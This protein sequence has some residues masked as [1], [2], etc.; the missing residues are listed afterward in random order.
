MRFFLDSKLMKIALLAIGVVAIVMIVSGASAQT[1]NTS[2]LTDAQKAQLALE[3]AQMAEQ[4]NATPQPLVEDR[5][6]QK[7]TEVGA[8]IGQALAGTAREL[9]VEVNN[10]AN[11][12]VG[13]LSVFLIVW[14][15]FG[16]TFLQVFGGLL[17]LS[18][19]IPIWIWSF[20]KNVVKGQLNEEREYEN[21]KGK[22]VK[23]VSYCYNESKAEWAVWHYVM[24][25]IIFL[26]WILV[27][28][29]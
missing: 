11:T 13:K 9:G 5:E 6:V 20:R 29:S 16:T 10:F 19:S 18:I 26:I 1:I 27:T 4:N 22:K 25:A 17:L 24:L 28:F 15:F 12:P 2:D 14:H 3:A 7:W 21:D 23:E 8:G